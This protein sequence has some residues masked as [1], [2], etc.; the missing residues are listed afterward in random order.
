ML[1][2]SVQND[3][4]ASKTAEAKLHLYY[5]NFSFTPLLT[6]QISLS[7]LCRIIWRTVN[8]WAFSLSFSTFNAAVLPNERQQQSW[9]I[10]RQTQHAEYCKYGRWTLTDSPSWADVS[11]LSVDFWGQSGHSPTWLRTRLLG[12]L[13]FL[14]L[15]HYSKHAAATVPLAV[16]QWVVL[17]HK[18]SQPIA[19]HLATQL[20]RYLEPCYSKDIQNMCADGF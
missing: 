17:V 8:I 20:S 2:W 16:T 19:F 12:G 13:L 6:N 3:S 18:H 7:L 5:F 15:G 14:E 9:Y 11:S 1:T 4:V 10:L